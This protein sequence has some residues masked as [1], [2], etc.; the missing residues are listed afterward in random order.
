MFDDVTVG[1]AAAVMLKNGFTQIPVKNRVDGRWR[2]VITD[3]STLR[4]LLPSPSIEISSL[5]E[6]KGMM[7]KDAGVIEVIADCPMDSTLGVVA[8]MLVHFYAVLLTDDF[9]EV[10]GIITRADILKLLCKNGS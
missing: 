2:G 1:A 9:G 6:F 5:A 8:Q 10:R 3:L 7:I 4:R